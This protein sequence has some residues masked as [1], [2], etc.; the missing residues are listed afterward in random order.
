MSAVT[1]AWR[2]APFLIGAYLLVSVVEAALPVATVWLVRVIVNGLVSRAPLPTLLTPATLLAAAGLLSA[3]T[4]QITRLLRADSQRAVEYFTVERLYQRVGNLVGLARFED[5]RFL[6][7]LGLAKGIG[8][9]SCGDAVYGSLGVARGVLTITG[10]LSSLFLLSP[11]LTAA[12]LLS[13]LPAFAG[14]YLISRQR[15]NTFWKTSSA[16]RRELFYSGLLASVDAAKEIR[17][18]GIGAYLR[19]KMLDE[20]RLADAAR[21]RVDRRETLV[22]T[23]LGTLAAVVAAAA[24]IWSVARAAGGRLSVGDVSMLI[25][26]IAAFQGAVGSVALQFG[27]TNQSLLLFQHYLSILNEPRDLPEPARPR[28]VP[29]LRDAIEFRDVWFRYSEQQRWILRGVNLRIPRGTA[30]GLVGLNGEGKST[31]VKLLCR[32]YDPSRGAI[33]WDGIDLRHF[34]AENLRARIGAVFQDCVRYELTVGENIGLGDLDRAA[35]RTRVEAAAV[36]AGAHDFVM[37]LP[38]RYDTLLSRTFPGDD[39]TGQN[40]GVDLSGGMWQRIALARVFLRGRRDL[41]ILDEA[42]SGLDAVAEHEINA[43]IRSQREGVTSVIVSHRLGTVRDADL[44]VYIADG[45]VAEKG[46]H[47]DLVRLGGRYAEAFTVQAA[48]YQPASYQAASCQEADYQEGLAEARP[49]DAKPLDAGPTNA[50]PT[51]AEP[52]NARPTNAEPLD[53]E[54]LDA[55]PTNAEPLDAE[56]L[57]ARPTNAEP[58]DAGPTNARPTDGGPTDGGPTDAG[59]LDAPAPLVGGHGRQ[60]VRHP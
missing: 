42:A 2:A 45:V 14:E 31:L 15:A 33:L 55:R 54:P 47:G 11:V 20:R 43:K 4:P 58:L 38:Q 1:L 46:T 34:S 30:V 9:D 16:Q 12:V 51:N 35:D 32:F 40:S 5:P 18:L 60:R 24:I 39:E 44:I 19:A 48:G 56:P 17:I 21:R 36:R 52:F 57:D 59:P 28:P 53:A 50:K 13:G 8:G 29:P 26:A 49:P 10:L 37:A 41:M 23:T 6:D 3:F 27:L 7:R 22:Q 25:G